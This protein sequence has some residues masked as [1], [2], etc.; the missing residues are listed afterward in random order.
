[1]DDFVSV[2]TPCY[3]GAKYLPGYFDGI[4]SQKHKNIEL[5][6]VD[7]GSVDATSEIANAYGRN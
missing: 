7:D 3:N 5:I 6:F 4:L 1:M 2:I